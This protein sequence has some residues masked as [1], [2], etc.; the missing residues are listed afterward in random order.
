M[1]SWNKIINLENALLLV[2]FLL[3]T[4]LIRFNFFGVP[5]NTL[6][7]LIVLILIFQI[8][9][10]A[11]KKTISD[12]FL[13]R[14][15]TFFFFASL[16]FLGLIISSLQ[17]PEIEKS[18]GIIKGWFVVPFIFL[19]LC[20]AIETPKKRKNVFYAYFLSC[21]SVAILS[22][23]YYFT[24]S[25]TYDGRLQAFFNSPNYLAMY[26]SPGLLIGI[27]FFL[28]R[29]EFEITKKRN[30][31]FIS[32]SFLFILGA[33]Y[34]TF[35]Y[36]A[37]IAVFF[38][39]LV[40]FFITRKV[41]WKKILLT[42][43]I[44]IILLFSQMGNPKFQ[45]LIDFDSR[46][47]LSSRLMIWRSSAKIIEDNFLLG[48]G[49][50]NF[51]AKYL[52]YQKFFPPYLEWAVPHPHNLFLAFWL[53]GGLLSLFGFLG[54]LFLFFKNMFRKKEWNFFN[55]AAFGIML[56]IVSHGL[57][58]TTYF[59]NDLAIVFWLTFLATK[60]LPRDR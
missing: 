2:V 8:F 58:D 51:Q 46:S 35:S 43:S 18:F 54:L 32:F 45:S 12:F 21:L 49:P 56:Y 11:P 5:T 29:E 24:D 30:I 36:A 19:F 33:F 38:S 7:I 22:L 17:N 1:K 41:S 28:S 10:S 40:I 23:F 50:A 34:L 9:S 26:L 3:P 6:E 27:S 31:I 16:I 39:S 13:T 48:I 52:E 53:S 60:K 59:K 44:I 14:E 37:W 42:L 20:F 25:L 47:S 15:K 57:F 55:L 4:Y